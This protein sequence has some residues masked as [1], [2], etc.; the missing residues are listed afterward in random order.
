MSSISGVGSASSAWPE[1]STAR[2]QGGSRKERMFAKADTN[3][4]GSV[5]SAELQSMLDKMAQKSGTTAPSADTLMQSMDTDGS[6]GLSADELDAGMKSLRA[7]ASSTV[8]FAQ[9]RAGDG[10]SQSVDGP[11]PAPSDATSATS[12]LDQM[13]SD[14]FT[15]ADSDG[16]GVL[17]KSELD[18]LKTNF[19]TAIQSLESGSASSTSSTGSTDATSGTSGTS[20][21]P[22]LTT[23]ATLTQLMLREYASTAASSAAATQ[24]TSTSISVTA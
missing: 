12:S 5:D 8:D 22:A 18:T 17:G 3:G 11:P 13:L 21:D 14:L 10:A 23:L 2:A 4:D 7:E 24:A 16:N 19:D 1:A 15:A 9:Q 6:G 20:T